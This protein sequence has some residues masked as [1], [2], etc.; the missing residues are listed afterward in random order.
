[1][2]RG[3]I[4]PDVTAVGILRCSGLWTTGAGAMGWRPMMEGEIRELAFGSAAGRNAGGTGFLDGAKPAEG[5]AA[6]WLAGIGSRLIARDA[7]AGDW[8]CAVRGLA[9]RDWIFSAMDVWV[10]MAM[11]RVVIAMLFFMGYVV[12]RCFGRSTS[13]CRF[14]PCL[15]ADPDSVTNFLKLFSGAQDESAM[16]RASSSS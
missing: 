12:F 1:L 5:M 16:R 14:I 7:A 2:V 11:A 6:R 4:V 10:R 9:M 3:L 13:V 8:I 15:A